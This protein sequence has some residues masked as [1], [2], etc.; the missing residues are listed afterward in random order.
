MSEKPEFLDKKYPDMPGS[1]PVERAVKRA[2]HDPERKFAPHDRS[3]RIQAY[4]DRLDRIVKDER[5]WELLKN[6]IVKEFVIDTD[7]EE[8][9]T[10]IA[11]G[12]YESEKRLAI[13]QGR[14]NDVARID[15]E[16]GENGGLIER[17]KGLTKEKH[18]IQE[19][20]LGSWLDYLEENDGHYPTWFGYFVVRNLQKMGALDKEKGEY[21]KRTDHTIAP[22]PEV[23]SEALGFVYRMLTTGIGHQE[24]IDTPD[25]REQLANLI[26]KKDFIKLY[27]FA[28]IETAGALNRESLQGEWVKYLQGSDYHKLE[29]SLHGKGTGWCT[30]EGSAPAHLQG[31]D[32]WVYFTR[33]KSGVYSEPR[34][35]IRMEGDSVAEVR[36]VNHRQELEPALVDVATEKYH[37][38]PGGEKFDKK[39]ADMKKMTE[40]TKKQEKGEQFTK[41]D[42]IFLYEIEAT[43]EGF[44]YDRDPRIT[45]LRKTR[46]PKEDAPIVLGCSSDQIAVTPEDVKENTKAYIGKLFPGVFKCGLEH[47][48]TAFPEGKIQKYNIEIGGKSKDN[49]KK[50]LKEKNIQFFSYAKDLMDSRDFQTS[51]N[52]ERVDLVRLTVRD[53]GFSESATTEEIYKRAE[54]MGLELCSPE[55][56]PRLRLV[57]SISDWTLIGMKPIN[58]RDGRP[59]VFNL[60]RDGAELGLLSDTARP[61]ESWRGDYRWVFALR[62]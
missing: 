27:T 44:G 55:V 49:L 62:K 14:G 42:L 54:E 10:K 38:L 52:T 25:K 11:T 31:G 24:F 32:F 57:T 18:D 58:D 29:D 46:N 5:G 9:M 12:L 40:L 39:S 19:K 60:R 51:E 8:T 33:G 16:L 61:R 21:G 36:G 34:I 59:S 22:F 53:M 28:Q 50:E 35:A 2:M 4:L 15:D 13:E 56:G 41:N 1:K 45:E 17:Y 20:T 37:S 3:E 26:E 43:I 6:K 48:Y 23:N 47:I 30:A 7:D